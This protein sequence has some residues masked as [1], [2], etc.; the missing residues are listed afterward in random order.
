MTPKWRVELIPKEFERP[1][2]VLADDSEDFFWTDDSRRAE[3]VADFLNLWQ[4]Y[5]EPSE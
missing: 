3:R 4:S 5:E 1:Y 2:V